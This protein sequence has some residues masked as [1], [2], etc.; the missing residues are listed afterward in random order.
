VRGDGR[1]VVAPA[2]YPRAW[3]AFG[4]PLRPAVA[5]KAHYAPSFCFPAFV[6]TSVVDQPEV[7]GPYGRIGSELVRSGD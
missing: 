3:R 5:R 4:G 7:R 1:Q 2:P 6:P